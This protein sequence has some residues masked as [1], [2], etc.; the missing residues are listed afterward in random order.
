MRCTKL[1]AKKSR[2]PE[3]CPPHPQLRA[4]TW[5]L[6]V[7]REAGSSTHGAPE[8][9]KNGHLQTDLGYAAA[10]ERMVLTEV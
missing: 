4:M 2:G 6:I 8:G 10:R 9:R 7:P 3:L 1:V 5:L